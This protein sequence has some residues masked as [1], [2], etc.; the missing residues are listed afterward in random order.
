MGKKLK[1]GLFGYYSYGNLGD[2]LMA[3]LLS[4]HIRS[5]GHEPILF[6][7]SP[8]FM[9]GWDVKL[10]ASTDDLVSQADVIVFGGGGL[11]IP[12]K[13][14][15]ETQADFTR[16]M[17]A[18]VRAAK[19][20]DIPR[21]GISLG[22]AG[23]SLDQI[24]PPERQELIR[25]L[26]HVTLRNSEDLQLLDQAN[27]D[28]AF[29]NDLV[30]TT[31]DQV[32]VPGKRASDRRRIGF[33]LYLTQSRRY[34]ILR[35]IL[36]MIIRLRPDLDFVFY[37]IHP[38]AGDEF[39]AFAPAHM[40]KNCTRKSL[41]DIEDSC[42]EAAT[43]DLLVSTRLHFGV[44]MMSYGGTTIAYAGQEKTRLLYTR[45]GREE[46][47]WNSNQLFKFV[48]CFLVPGA[49]EKTISIGKSRAVSD[50]VDDARQHYSRLGEL[51]EKISYQ[52]TD[53]PVER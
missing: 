21:I 2:N 19:A 43:L 39:K 27:L 28:G 42:R 53:P 51:L 18:V 10:C 14:M 34:R 16:D 36:G 52:R 50:V 3:Y 35:K 38:G 41:T 7:K 1:V 5:L 45:I 31:A 12:R 30:W 22:G 26:D 15:N 11:L 49:L 37:D 24:T 8:D 13:N 32:P 20:K 17:G 46:L 33:N 47:F 44:M 25:E 4:R 29:F 23:K 6:T 9:K 48:Q 40:P